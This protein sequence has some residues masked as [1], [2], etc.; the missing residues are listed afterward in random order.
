MYKVAQI[1]STSQLPLLLYY[2]QFKATSIFKKI[3]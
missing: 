1:S 2:F 3:Y